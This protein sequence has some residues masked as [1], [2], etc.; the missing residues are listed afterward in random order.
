MR[1]LSFKVRHSLRSD[2]VESRWEILD[3][4]NVIGGVLGE[5]GPPVHN[6][7]T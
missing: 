2:V 6:I 1:S 5:C 4:I 7:E 3:H